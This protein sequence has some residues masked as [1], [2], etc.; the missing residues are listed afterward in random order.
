MT[1]GEPDSRTLHVELL[2]VIEALRHHAAAEPLDVVSIIL[3]YRRVQAL[4][5]VAA[6][7][8]FDW[9]AETM[10]AAP[11]DEDPLVF[12]VMSADLRTPS[13]I[14]EAPGDGR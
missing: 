3:T 6:L 14:V 10:M 8:G 4:E 13:G 9:A 2:R 11:D 7:R 1:P 5:A 12:L